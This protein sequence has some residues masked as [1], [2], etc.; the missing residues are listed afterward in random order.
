[1]II[2]YKNKIIQIKIVYYGCAMS[3]KT[4]S[5]KAL[6]FKFEHEKFLTSIETTAG[7]TLFFDYGSLMMKGGEWKIKIMLYSATGQDFY[8]ATRPATLSGADGII[9]MVDSQRKYLLDNINSWIELKSYYSS[10][11]NQIP[12]VICLNKQDLPEI[13]SSEEIITNFQINNRDNFE[14]IETIAISGVGVE[15]SFKKI[16]SSI[17][18]SIKI[19]V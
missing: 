18:P 4:T 14:L 8:A 19:T 11:F 1:M 13:V 6:F 12:I 15:F 5:L 10:C 2:N 7:R 9:F 17:F 3:G 16:L